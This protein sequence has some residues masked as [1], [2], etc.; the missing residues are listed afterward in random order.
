MQNYPLPM[1]VVSDFMTT[2]VASVRMDSEITEAVALLVDHRCAGVPVVNADGGVVG[3]LTHHGAMRALAGAAF[4]GEETG[5]VADHMICDCVVVESSTD[6]FGVVSMFQN[7]AGRRVLVAEH[8]RLVG[9]VTRTDTI[10]ALEQLRKVRVQAGDGVNIKTV[11]LG[12]SAL[13][14]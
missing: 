5:R 14:Q 2:P 11:A 9:I 8:G 4:N 7:G 10:R 13:T 6:L 1:P 12:W 3:V